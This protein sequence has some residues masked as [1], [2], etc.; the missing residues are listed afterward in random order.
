MC[1]ERKSI[2]GDD[3]STEW[4]PTRQTYARNAQ[5]VGV[6]PGCSL[7]L[8]LSVTGVPNLHA[9]RGRT[10]SLL[11]RRRSHPFGLIRLFLRIETQQHHIALPAKQEPQSRQGFRRMGKCHAYLH[12]RGIFLVPLPFDST[13]S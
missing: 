1:G 3:L 6:R 7:V 11:D 8:S 10:V 4:L 13:F 12:Q 5:H 2:C 9:S